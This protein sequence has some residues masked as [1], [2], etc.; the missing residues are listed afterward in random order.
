MSDRIVAGT[1]IILAVMLNK[2]FIVK[3]FNP[4]Y[5]TSLLNILKKMKAKFKS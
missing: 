4:K 3:N 5:L 2:K 1:F